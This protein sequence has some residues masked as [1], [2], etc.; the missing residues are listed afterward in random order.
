MPSDVDISVDTPRQMCSRDRILVNVQGAGSG[1]S[2]RLCVDFWQLMPAQMHAG[3]SE[4]LW[5]LPH[6]IWGVYILLNGCLEKVKGKGLGN[7][8]KGRVWEISLPH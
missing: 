3:T 7:K 1:P 8:S 4:R 6:N 2:P 5:T